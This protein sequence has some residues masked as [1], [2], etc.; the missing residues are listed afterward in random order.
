MADQINLLMNILFYSLFVRWSTPE[1]WRAF[2]RHRLCNAKAEIQTSGILRDKINSHLMNGY[3]DLRS[4][5]DAVESAL[6][7]R[8]NETNDSLYRL[9]KHLQMVIIS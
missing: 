4:Q 2:T 5:A 3:Q 6:S 8:I 1:E 7:R 9:K